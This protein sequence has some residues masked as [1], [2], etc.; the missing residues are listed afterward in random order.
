M[1]EGDKMQK[2]KWKFGRYEDPETLG[3]VGQ[4]QFCHYREKQRLSWQFYIR[5]S[6][7]WLTP[8]P[9]CQQELDEILKEEPRQ[10]IDEN[11]RLA[12]DRFY[13]LCAHCKDQA[14][15]MVQGGELIIGNIAYEPRLELSRKWIAI[16]DTMVEI[17]KKDYQMKIAPIT[18]VIKARVSKRPPLR[19]TINSDP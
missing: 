6:R 19:Q 3:R 14:Y 7:S 18:A 11:P 10:F 8:C 5:T 15:K 12:E 9:R 1:K 16:K 17:T 13:Q 2:E 4:R